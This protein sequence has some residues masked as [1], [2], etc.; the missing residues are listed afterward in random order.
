M[1]CHINVCLQRVI[2]SPDS[3]AALKDGRF[4]KFELGE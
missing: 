4:R 2:V 1:E 3:D